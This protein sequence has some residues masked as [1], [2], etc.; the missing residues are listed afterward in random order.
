M[1]F[2]LQC[3]SLHNYSKNFKLLTDINQ[4]GRSLTNLKAYH[5]QLPVSEDLTI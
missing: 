3:L 5:S 1:P 2:F 4:F